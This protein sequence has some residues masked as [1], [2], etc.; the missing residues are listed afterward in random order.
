MLI[1]PIL[2]P[3]ELIGFMVN[4]NLG[5]CYVFGTFNLNQGPTMERSLNDTNRIKEYMPNRHQ[6]QP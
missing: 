5:P 3:N 2:S 4:Y 6:Q 1:G